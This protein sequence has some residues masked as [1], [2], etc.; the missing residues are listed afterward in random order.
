MR[1]S[2]IKIAPSILAA[3]L[4]RL[5]EQVAE[6]ERCG[7]DRIH[8]DV[9]DGHFVPNISLGAVVVEALRP[10]TRLPLEVHLMITDPDMFLDEFAAAGADSFLV[11][12]KGTIICIGQFSASRRWARVPE[13]LS[14]RRRSQ[15]CLRRS[16]QLWTRCSS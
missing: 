12:W 8:V 9:M 7:A 13:W 16:C 6:A 4:S 10:V 11:H 2:T 1:Q 15:S 5:G 3:N 14:T